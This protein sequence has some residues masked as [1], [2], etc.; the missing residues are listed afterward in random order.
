MEHVIDKFPLR[1]CLDCKQVFEMDGSEIWYHVD[2]PTYGI[3]REKCCNC[4]E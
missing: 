4:G 2:F 3:E 1:Y